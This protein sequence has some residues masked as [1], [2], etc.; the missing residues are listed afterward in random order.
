VS[1][2]LTLCGPKYRLARHLRQLALSSASLT[3]QAAL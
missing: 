1:F 2:D 3:T